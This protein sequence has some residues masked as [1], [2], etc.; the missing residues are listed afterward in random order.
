MVASLQGGIDRVLK[1][2]GPVLDS[3]FDAG[4]DSDDPEQ[5]ELAKSILT[6]KRDEFYS[7]LKKTCDTIL[8]NF[9]N[10][11]KEALDDS[12]E[13]ETN[14]Q[15]GNLFNL[16]RA[17]K[18]KAPDSVNQTRLKNLIVNGDSIATGI[19][20]EVSK[21]AQQLVEEVKEDLI[22]ALMAEFDDFRN[23]FAHM[24]AADISGYVNQQQSEDF[25]KKTVEACKLLLELWDEYT[26]TF[27]Q[28]V[29]GSAAGTSTGEAQ[30]PPVLLQ[31]ASSL[32]K[33]EEML[34]KYRA[35]LARH[36]PN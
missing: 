27:L 15:L 24:T 18:R 5:R 3:Q 25:I 9:E 7:K 12:L 1:G 2:L 31:G 6:D 20:R 34:H 19:A 10:S 33:Q 4:I 26:R 32:A 8:E 11:S 35:F 30:Q 14:D 16:T 28:P 17:L 29:A 22:K 13:E 21:T 23:Q 36:L